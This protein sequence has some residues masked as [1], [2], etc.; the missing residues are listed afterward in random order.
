MCSQTFSL[1]AIASITS[2]REVVRVRRREPD[3]PEPV[4]LVHLLEQLREERPARRPGNRDV[5]PV[6]VHVLSEKRHLDDAVAREALHLREH[7]A[8][9]PGA[10][11]APDERHDAE[12]AGVVASDRDRHPGPEGVV[13]GGRE[14]RGEQLRVLGDVHLRTVVLRSPEEI[15]QVREGRGC[16]R[17]RR[18]T[19][20][21]PGSAPDPSGPGSR[22][23]RSAGRGFC[24]FSGLRCPRLP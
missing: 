16:R 13:P 7:V 15:Q 18:P 24:A 21:S 11:R 12:R 8:D 10:L 22:R 1:S 23:R 17:P 4:D 5:A 3:P 9:R 6:G 14:R 19:A 20:P 2:G